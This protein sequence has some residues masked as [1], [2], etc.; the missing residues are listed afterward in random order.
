MAG[1]F[2]AVFCRNVM[3]YFDT[4]TPAALVARFAALLAPG[5]YLCVGHAESLSA[6]AH[7]LAY[8]LAYGQPAAYRKAA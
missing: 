6:V 8:G 3:I 7:G 5:G 4:A 1:P 2:H